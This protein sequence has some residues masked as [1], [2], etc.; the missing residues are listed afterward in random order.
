MKTKTAVHR[1]LTVLLALCLLLPGAA[2]AKGGKGKKNFDEGKKYEQTQQWDVAAQ[3]FAL[4]VNAEPNNAEYKLHYLQSVQKASLMFIKRGDD[5]AND[6]D[7]EGAYNSYRNAYQYDQGNELAKLKMNRMMEQQKQVASGGSSQF[8]TNKV[9]NVVNTSGELPIASKPRGRDLVP[10]IN[11]S[12]GSKFKTVVSHLGKQLGLNVVFDDSIKE[13]QTLN[14]AID[15]ESVTMAKALDIILRAY[16]C[17]FELID[18]RTILVYAD[19]GTNRPRFETLMV[20]PFYLNNVNANQARAALQIVLPPGRTMAPLESGANSSGGNVLVVKA[21]ATELQLVQ[22][23]LDAIDKNKNEVVMDVDIY[24]VSKNRATD[25]GNQI[26]TGGSGTNF[27]LT[28]FGGVSTYANGSGLL[29]AQPFTPGGFFALPLTQVKLSQS[30]GDTK[31]LYKT[32]IHV[33][34]GQE[35]KTTVGRS[36]PVR[37]GATSLGGYYGGG[38]LGGTNGQQGNTGGITGALNGLLGNNGLGLGS[39]VVDNIQYKDVGLVI[40]TTPTITSEGYVEVKMEFETSDIAASASGDPLN[41]TFTQRKLKSTARMQDGVVSVVAGINQ[42]QKINQ[43]AGVPIVSMVPLLGRFLSAPHNENNLTDIII[44]VTPHIVR[45]AGINEKDHLARAAGLQT[46]GPGPSVEEVVYRAQ[47]EEE[48]DR[49]QIAQQIPQPDQI[50]PS[51]PGA[52]QAA[53][54]TQPTRTPATQQTFR[55]VSNNNPGARVESVANSQ[56]ANPAAPIQQTDLL[57]SVLQ[58][59]PTNVP[60]ANG[61]GGNAANSAVSLSLSPKPIRQQPGKSFTVAVEMRSQAQMMGADLAISFDPS[62]LRVKNVR[63]GGMFGAQPDPTYEV[64]NGSLAVKFK[65]PQS[66]P[67]MAS[68]GRLILIEFAA[69]AEGSSEINF[70]QAAT[71]ISMAGNANIKPTGTPTQVIIS[72]DGGATASQ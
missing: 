47:Q 23:I 68:S 30:K 12:K 69:I 18:R 31:L 49:R 42:D 37:T 57:T 65:S 53:A 71:Q 22:D 16:K 27:G 19:N 24:E 35:N 58:S 64:A 29:G 7:Y 67:A 36:V 52:T 32:Q 62:K 15:L 17:S 21:T 41:P 45:S 10:S 1:F 60:V 59:T 2:L 56:P 61:N 25:I 40:T 70:N 3:K 14:D 20:K 38:L 34:D 26:A 46:A 5:L 54:F 48:Q 28:N 50:N 39:G 44:T 11:Y 13:S 55:P 63:D 51:S 6:G 43:N 66:A 72:R 33:L 8:A 9:G 4:A